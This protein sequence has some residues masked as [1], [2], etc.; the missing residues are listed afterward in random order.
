MA[1]A[2]FHARLV[3]GQNSRFCSNVRLADEVQEKRFSLRWIDRQQRTG[4][5]R[6]EAVNGRR[7]TPSWPAYH[8]PAR[9]RPKNT[10]LVTWQRL[11]SGSAQ[12]GQVCGW[13]GL[14]PMASSLAFCSADRGVCKLFIFI[15]IFIIVDYLQYFQ[16]TSTC[17]SLLAPT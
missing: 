17:S 8:L 3:T 10:A 15:L 1:T 7:V 13:Q 11:S 12:R 2:R 6:A 16:W 9:E 5:I 14:S 4:T